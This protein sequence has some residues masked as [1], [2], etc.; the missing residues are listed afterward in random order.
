MKNYAAAIIDYKSSIAL[1]PSD[2]DNWYNL[3]LSQRHSN[4][5]Q[6]AVDSI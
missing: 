5:L 1:D 4:D 6:G 3:G 2:P